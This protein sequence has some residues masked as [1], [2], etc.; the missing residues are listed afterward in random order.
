M[1]LDINCTRDVLLFLESAPSVITNDSGDVEV[2]GAW[3]P[4]ICN[5]LAKY[6][7]E[8]VY[9]TLARL[10]EAGFLDLSTE[11]AGNSLYYCCVNFIT[12]AGHEFL[13]KIRPPT[14]WE[15]TTKIAGKLGSFSLKII[16]KIAE[17]VASACID[18]LIIGN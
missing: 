6:P 5:A 13:E 1:K 10:E 12:F 11:W 18:R 2:V 14:V 3:F 4:Q 9:Y 17:G 16:E 8:E 15:K 7:Q